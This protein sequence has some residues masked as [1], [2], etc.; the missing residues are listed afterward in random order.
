[1]KIRQTLLPLIIVI[2][3]SSGCASSLKVLAG[4]EKMVRIPQIV[5]HLEP[6]LERDKFLVFGKIV[7]QNPGESDL[8][9]DRI[10]L[11]IQDE[12]GNLLNK[13]EANWQRR[14][15]KSREFI[16]A[17]VRF[18]LPLEV[19][20]KDL[21]QITLITN[22]LYKKLNI[23]LPIKSKVAVLHLKSFKNSLSGPLELV[24]NSKL[25]SDILGNASIEYTLDITNPFNVDLEMD[26]AML[27][28]YTQQNSDI[29]ETSLAKT[30]LIPKKINRI[31][32]MIKL[33][34]AFSAVIIR[35]FIAGHAVRSQLKGNLRVAKTD[36]LIP[37]TV[38]SAQEIDFSLFK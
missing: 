21:I 1:M 9:L 32:G 31:S 24:V 35:E 11:I 20:N 33:K 22:L 36:I 7:L 10:T 28:I 13:T 30:L 6:S 15:I 16:Q 19:L 12:S 37:F 34:K 5:A 2:L 8:S 27:K 29:G 18:S 4:R 17:P 3:F 25:R 23:Q 26:E 14:A 38:E